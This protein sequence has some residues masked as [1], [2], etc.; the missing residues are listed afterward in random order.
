VSSKTWRK[1]RAADGIVLDSL[2]SRFSDRSERSRRFLIWTVTKPAGFRLAE[3]GKTSTICEPVVTPV[4]PS[5]EPSCVGVDFGF[6]GD[7]HFRNH[8]EN[9]GRFHP[10]ASRGSARRRG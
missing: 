4:R 9:P 6:W 3:C 1:T 10:L 8:R 7:R 5:C 2:L